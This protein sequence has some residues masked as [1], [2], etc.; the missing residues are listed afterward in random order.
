MRVVAAVTE[1]FDVT[2]CGDG[3]GQI[4]YLGQSRTNDNSIELPACFVGFGL[5]EAYNQGFV[6]QVDT[7]LAALRVFDADGD[8]ALE[9]AFIGRAFVD[10]SQDFPSCF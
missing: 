10:L 2:I 3:A 8:L 6:Y 1:G 5:F 7:E 9:Q 4:T